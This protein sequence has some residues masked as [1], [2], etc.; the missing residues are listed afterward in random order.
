MR[1]SIRTSVD[2]AE[3]PESETALSA[4]LSQANKSFSG[5]VRSSI[6]LTSFGRYSVLQ[7]LRFSP[8]LVQTVFETGCLK[9]R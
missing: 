7:K 1:L 9:M 5:S 3:V 2:H 8:R 4:L 6:S